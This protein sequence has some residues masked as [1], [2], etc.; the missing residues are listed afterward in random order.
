MQSINKNYLYVDCKTVV[1]I[2]K[3]FTTWKQLQKGRK[4]KDLFYLHE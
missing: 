4:V 3:S 1:K 2:R